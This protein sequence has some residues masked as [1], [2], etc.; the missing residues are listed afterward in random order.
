MPRIFTPGL[1]EGIRA[2]FQQQGLQSLDTNEVLVLITD[3]FGS[4]I[5]KIGNRLGRAT[6]ALWAISLNM[7][8][9]LLA[10][11]ILAVLFAD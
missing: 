9:G 2:K 1:V 8:A 4:E 11:I 3:H 7:L 5:E 10:G 6:A